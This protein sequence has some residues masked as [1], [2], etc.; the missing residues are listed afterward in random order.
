MTTYEPECR[1]TV[2]VPWPKIHQGWEKIGAT[3]GSKKFFLIASDGTWIPA[4]TLH[5]AVNRWLN[6]GR[7]NCKI[8]C[9]VGADGK[10]ARCVYDG[11][12]WGEWE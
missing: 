1:T 6:L 2:A 12:T 11:E 3:I 4:V 8:G 7:H 5:V 9:E 10:T